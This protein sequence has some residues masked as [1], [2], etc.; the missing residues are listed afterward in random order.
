MNGN[1]RQRPSSQPRSARQ[2]IIQNARELSTEY[3]NARGEVRQKMQTRINTVTKQVRKEKL[4]YNE[5][6]YETGDFFNFDGCERYIDNYG[7]REEL[8]RAFVYFLY[9]NDTDRNEIETAAWIQGIGVLQAITTYNNDAD[10]ENNEYLEVDAEKFPLN[11]QSSKFYRDNE[12]DI[13]TFKIKDVW[14]LGLTTGSNTFEVGTEELVEQL[15]DPV[16]VPP[17]NEDGT[18]FN[19]Q[20]GPIKGNPHNGFLKFVVYSLLETEEISKIIG[21]IAPNGDK[22]LLKINTD[23]TPIEKYEIGE[24][25]IKFEP[26]E[27]DDGII[28]NFNV[29]LDIGSQDEKAQEISDYLQAVESPQSQSQETQEEQEPLIQS[30]PIT[31]AEGE[32]VLVN[33][34]LVEDQSHTEQE[35]G[36]NLTAARILER[37]GILKEQEKRNPSK[38]LA[39]LSNIGISKELILGALAADKDVPDNKLEISVFAVVSAIVTITF[40]KSSLPSVISGS[41]ESSAS[42]TGVIPAVDDTPS[43]T[44]ETL[45]LLRVIR[46]QEDLHNDQRTKYI[47]DSPF[48]VKRNE[49]IY[50]SQNTEIT[51]Q[52]GV[53]INIYNNIEGKENQKLT[54]S[55]IEITEDNTGKKIKLKKPGFIL[56]DSL[57]EPLKTNM[58]FMGHVAYSLKTKFQNYKTN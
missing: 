39:L 37:R 5:N 14:D 6:P 30:E 33:P 29:H 13:K 44:V 52:K 41:E 25:T 35:N 15:I 46:T 49:A 4:R 23:G 57:Q 47:I 48:K 40:N 22:Y 58:S 3:K 32:R 16:V 55:D 12:N 2:D 31:N 36:S 53:E 8:I 34:N 54:S 42:H 19:I 9:Y 24:A 10:A 26:I 45:S 11:P 51:M 7:G 21:Y 18:F 1:P 56:H 28:E 17:N 27:D 43:T 50:M 38:L 20:Q